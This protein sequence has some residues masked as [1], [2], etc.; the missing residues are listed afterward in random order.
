MQVHELTVSIADCY[1]PALKDTAS[2][3][4]LV[5]VAGR[6]QEVEVTIYSVQ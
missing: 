5:S 2:L 3:R 4:F 1:L 6:T